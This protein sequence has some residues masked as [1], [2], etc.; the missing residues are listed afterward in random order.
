M[1]MVEKSFLGT[2]MKAEYLLKDTVI[3]PEQLES[4]RHK[5][6]MQRM[7]ELTQKGKNIDL[8]TSQRSLTSNHL[9]EFHTFRSCYRMEI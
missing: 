6:I 3:R 5:A 4:T 7:L 2:L 8:I 1:S 9:A